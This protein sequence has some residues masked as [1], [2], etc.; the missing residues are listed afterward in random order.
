VRTGFNA[1]GARV[2]RPA[3]ASLSQSHIDFQKYGSVVALTKSSELPDPALV[4]IEF[5]FGNAAGRRRRSYHYL[6]KYPPPVRLAPC[7]GMVGTLCAHIFDQFSEDAPFGK[8]TTDLEQ[9]A[10]Q[11]CRSGKS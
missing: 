5:D 8:G 7:E 11:L 9:A 4:A 1:I 3:F 6:A 2:H 10:L